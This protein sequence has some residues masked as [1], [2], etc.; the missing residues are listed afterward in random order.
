MARRNAKTKR[1]GYAQSCLTGD[2]PLL[3]YG[4]ANYALNSMNSHA[5][6]TG[7]EDCLRISND[8]VVRDCRRSISR[9]FISGWGLCR[10][11]LRPTKTLKML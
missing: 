3:P 8:E 5:K 9:L 4:H 6:H 7:A 2:I 11:Q 1:D 10:I